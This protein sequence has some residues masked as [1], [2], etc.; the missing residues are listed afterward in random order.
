MYCTY[1]SS[2][3]N[4]D[5]LSLETLNKLR[6]LVVE[7]LP[8]C[9]SMAPVF[10]MVDCLH[11]TYVELGRVLAQGGVVLLDKVPANLILGR[12]VAGAGGRVS[13]GGGCRSSV[14]LLVTGVAVCCHGA[15]TLGLK[16]ILILSPECLVV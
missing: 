6:L 8:Q 14:L 4:I 16:R 9:Q 2:N 12:V 3:G 13:L 11:C 10:L 7:E 15:V 5:E 1:L